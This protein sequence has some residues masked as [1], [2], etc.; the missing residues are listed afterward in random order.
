MNYRKRFVVEKHGAGTVIGCCPVA[1]FLR[2]KH[3]AIGP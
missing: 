1:E 2:G 3:I